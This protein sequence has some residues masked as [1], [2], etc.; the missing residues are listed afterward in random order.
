M[1]AKTVLKRMASFVL[2]GAAALSM[3]VF[4][5]ADG[6]AATATTAPTA[7]SMKE[8]SVYLDGVRSE[9]EG[10]TELPQQTV[11]K[12]GV[13]AKLNTWIGTDGKNLY[14]FIEVTD[15]S[16]CKTG[17]SVF[18]D[19]EN[20]HDQY[21]TADA[22]RA[23]LDA[24]TTIG[25]KSFSLNFLEASSSYT[26]Y[27]PNTTDHC[28]AN[29]DSKYSNL[30]NYVLCHEDWGLLAGFVN[31][32]SDYSSYAI[33]FSVPLPSD[34]QTALKS[35]TYTIGTDTI[36][37]TS[38][39]SAG[40]YDE[41]VMSADKK[42]IEPALAH[43]VIL[44]QTKTAE[45]TIPVA[46]NMIGKTVTLNGTRTANEGWTVQ[47]TLVAD[48][49]Q[50]TLPTYLWLGTDGTKIYGFVE[51]SYA[52]TGL[53]DV[54]LK[55]TDSETGK[56]EACHPRFVNNRGDWTGEGANK[57]L[58]VW[59][60]KHEL[61]S[62]SNFAVSGKRSTGTY[63]D[64]FNYE[65]AL[66]L[67]SYI[68]NGL[69]NGTVTISADMNSSQKGSWNLGYQKE[70]GSNVIYNGSTA[71]EVLRDVILPS[72]NVEVIGTQNGVKD[73]KGAVRFVSALYQN[74]D[75]TEYDTVGFDVTLNGKIVSQACNMVYDSISANYGATEVTATSQGA[76]YLFALTVTDLALDTDYTFTVQ[77]WAKTEGGETVKGVAYTITVRVAAPSQNTEQA[78]LS[79]VDSDPV[80]L[81]L[82]NELAAAQGWT[83][84][85][86]KTAF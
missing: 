49:N 48:D 80:A 62:W 17:I 26:I 42:T 8:N 75:Y 79:A 68:Q 60:P 27:H 53:L 71:N 21:E 77:P 54:C 15:R 3:T 19:Y 22:Y 84:G 70:T 41:S 25:S 5:G 81:N 30:G 56:S 29:N 47:P 66:V 2:A 78:S 18:A 23:M 16:S 82:A 61:S 1:N 20:T 14:Y 63:E 13:A 12:E 74:V 28:N 73:N 35:G 86:K 51:G 69:K 6:A 4:V 52:Y 67:P 10:W 72:S 64:Y 45:A 83:V 36:G 39:I 55:F 44:P 65:F 31:V 11:S 38:W 32:A 76:K 50:S 57:E 46:A 33:E 40:L 9:A 43:D 24:E 37:Y 58:I 85:E 34:V 7:A 59:G